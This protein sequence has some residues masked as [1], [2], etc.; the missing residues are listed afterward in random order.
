MAEQIEPRT[1]LHNGKWLTEEGVKGQTYSRDATQAEIAATGGAPPPTAPTD[2]AP[3]YKPTQ[4]ERKR[5]KAALKKLS[6]DTA[7]DAGN[8]SVSPAELAGVDAGAATTVTEANTEAEQ[9]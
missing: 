7:P 5:Q 6:E 3:E 8:L 4:A 2:V 9:F 1:Y